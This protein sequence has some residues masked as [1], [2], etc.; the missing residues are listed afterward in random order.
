MAGSAKAAG[1]GD[2]A[3]RR[4]T[5][6]GWS[7]WFAVLDK[8]GAEA[9]P[10]R[11]I[12]R[13]LRE[14]HGLSGWWSQMVTVGYEQA[15]GLRKKHQ[16]P[17]GFA[18]SASRTVAAAVEN[19]FAALADPRRRPRWLP[20]A[21]A[22][23]EAI[24]PTSLRAMWADGTRVDIACSSKGRGESQVVVQHGKLPNVRAAERMKLHWIDALASLKAYLEG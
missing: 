2:A 17:D 14:D 24:R 5:G 7:E 18:V 9:Q 12:A 4:A 11:E 1:V 8:A 3:V 6:R 10:H 21:L 22:V 15:R 19:L 23:H 16:K 13:L 20:G